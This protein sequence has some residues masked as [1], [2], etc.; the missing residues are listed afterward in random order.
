M[1]TDFAF[2][3]LYFKGIFVAS[4]YSYS[5]LFLLA[6]VKFY[7]WVL[8]VFVP[9]SQDNSLYGTYDQ[10]CIRNNFS[11]E[12]TLKFLKTSKKSTNNF[13][14]IKFTIFI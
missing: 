12:K 9:T 1:F 7:Y 4:V 3:L 8:T 14:S 11:G 13:I 5:I 6:S 10:I 2:Q